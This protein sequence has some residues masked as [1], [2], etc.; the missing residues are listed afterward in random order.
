M[1]FLLRF[2]NANGYEG[3][4]NFK[5]PL[6]S[7][8][9]QTDLRM[10]TLMDLAESTG[11]HYELLKAR[12]GMSYEPEL[13]RYRY[14]FEFI[15][16]VGRDAYN[17]VSPRVC[18]ACLQDENHL[19]LAWERPLMVVCEEHRRLLQDQCPQCGQQLSWKRRHFDRCDCGLELAAWEHA[20][21]DD[22]LFE[23]QWLVFHHRTTER[24]VQKRW[25]R[26]L[27]RNFVHLPIDR[28]SLAVC[29]FV[30]RALLLVERRKEPDTYGLR[31]KDM[32]CGARALLAFLKA[33]PVFCLQMLHLGAPDMQTAGP[34]RQKRDVAGSAQSLAT[35]RVQAARTADR[36]FA[37]SEERV[38]GESC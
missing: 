25:L 36:A 5:W 2:A 14:P 34:K 11:H 29:R 12:L 38:G 22:A 21:A 20:E 23:F 30:Y 9:G 31:V 19:R 35:F 24:S 16:L 3:L 18:P 32:A 26:K 13:D 6:R 27:P 7:V 33:D 8:V 10:L 37:M 17:L 4:H 28:L 1:G 15:R